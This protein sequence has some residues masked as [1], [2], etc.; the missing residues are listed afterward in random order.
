MC[1]HSLLQGIFL[2]LGSNLGLLHCRAISYHLIHQGSLPKTN[3]GPDRKN[4][5]PIQ[6]T[7]LTRA[8][9]SHGGVATLHSLGALV[10]TVVRGMQRG[11]WEQGPRDRR[12]LQKHPEWL[13]PGHEQGGLRQE[14]SNSC[15]SAGFYSLEDMEEFCSQE[16][17]V[18][19]CVDPLGGPGG[20]DCKS[21]RTSQRHPRE[22]GWGTA[23]LEVLP[24]WM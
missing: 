10:W 23:F 7:S 6:V 20:D 15:W 13:S 19:L 2:T 21:W 22:P 4:P 3:H 1:C 18:D 16:H 9:G 8:L 5:Q 12:E 14:A 17:L 11:G 24:S